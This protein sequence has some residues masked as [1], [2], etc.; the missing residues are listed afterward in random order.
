MAKKNKG[1]VVVQRVGSG[2]KKV[3]KPSVVVGDEDDRAFYD[4]DEAGDISLLMAEEGGGLSQSQ[5]GLEGL[6]SSFRDL[7]AWRVCIPSVEP[8]IDANNKTYYAFIVNVTRIDVTGAEHPDEVHWEVERRYHEFYILETKLTEFHGE[9]QDNQLPPR[10]SLFTSKDIGFMQSRRQIF[11]E[12][13]QKLLQK[14]ALKGSQLLF[15]FLKTKDEFT[16][17]YLPDV[18]IGRLIR[19][20]PRKLI[21]ER[22]Q[23][24]DA[25]ISVF[26]SSTVTSSKTKSK[27]EWDDMS[28]ANDQS[29]LSGPSKSLEHCLFGNNA[30]TLP[31]PSHDPP[32]P[33]PATMNVTGVYDTV[34]YLVVRVY[35][36]SIS[37]LRWCMCIRLLVGNTVDAA[38]SW[39]LRRKLA[40]ALAPPRIIKLIHLVRDALFLDPPSDRTDA[41]K[42]CRE[43]DLRREVISLLPSWLRKFLF[44]EDHYHEGANT[45]VNLFQQPVLNKQLSYVLLDGVINQ[46]FPELT[47]EPELSPFLNS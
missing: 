5:S 30:K 4:I 45:L 27:L 8:R 44:T 25:F 32:P 1:K 6:T 7:S 41:D 35:G 46:L 23:H 43:N 28:S 17:T 9:F 2:L 29:N 33:P 12:F 18:S 20:V 16:N 36:L 42:R 24:L 34:L 3:L 31:S 47:L 10:R 37:A 15:L 40:L 39:Y 22:G 21:K 19:D 11:E 14:H 26:L 38:I 13:L